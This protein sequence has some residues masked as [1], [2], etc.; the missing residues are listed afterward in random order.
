MSMYVALAFFAALVSAVEHRKMLFF[1]E[2]SAF[3]GHS[4]AY[5]VVGSIYFII[6]EAECF[7][8]VEVRSKVLLQG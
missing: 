5:I 6:A 4:T 3:Y 2:G 1:Q 7:Q 8:Q